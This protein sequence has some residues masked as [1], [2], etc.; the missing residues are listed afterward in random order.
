MANHCYGQGKHNDG[1]IL[2]LKDQQGMVL[3]LTGQF[4]IKTLH[5]GIVMLKNLR[6]FPVI[7]TAC[8]LPDGEF[9][10]ALNSIVLKIISRILYQKIIMTGM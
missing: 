3:L 6:A 9:L 2:I 10:P 8:N 1:V 5:P 4:D 7:K